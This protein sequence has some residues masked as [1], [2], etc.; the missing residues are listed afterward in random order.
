MMLDLSFVGVMEHMQ[1]LLPT[2]KGYIVLTDQQHMP[3][4]TTLHSVMCYEDLL[5]VGLLAEVATC[6]FMA[7]ACII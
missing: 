5:S 6:K 3:A 7:A 1:H 2:V 4:E